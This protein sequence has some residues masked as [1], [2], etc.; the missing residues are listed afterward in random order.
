[1]MSEGELQVFDNITSIPADLRK[2]I[3]KFAESNDYCIK[4][5]AQVQKTMTTIDEKVNTT[6]GKLQDMSD[7]LINLFKVKDDEFSVAKIIENVKSHPAG[8][9]ANITSL[10]RSSD[11][12]DFSTNL[13]SLASL[14]GFEQPI[15][16][17]I[18]DRWT[19]IEDSV[20]CNRYQSEASVTKMACLLLAILGK[21]KLGFGLTDLASVIKDTKKNASVYKDLIEEIEDFA[22][23]HGFG[24][25]TRAKLVKEMKDQIDEL[26]KKMQEFEQIN[27]VCPIKFCRQTVYTDFKTLG[28]TI[29][30]CVVDMS[31][32]KMDSFIGTS[33]AATI[34]TLQQRFCK[35]KVSVEQVRRTN[36]YRV[37]PQGLVLLGSESQIGKSYLME[38]IENRVKKELFRRYKADPE[39]ET[40]QAFADVE[41]WET[42]NQSLRDKY[43]QN[44][45]GQEG[46]CIDDCFTNSDHMEHPMLIT[47]ISPRAIPTYQAD[48]TSK[49][50]PYN[51]RY[52]MLSCN[53]FPRESKTISNPHALANRFP[54]FVHCSLKPGQTPPPP[55]EDGTINRDFD[56]L[57]LHLSTGNRYY[58]QIKETGAVVC[59]TCYGPC[60][61]VT[62][63]EI[64][65]QMVTR[66]IIAQKMY[67]SQEKAY[68]Q[69]KFEM[70]YDAVSDLYRGGQVSKLGL[71]ES[72]YHGFQR[73]QIPNDL[74]NDQ[75]IYNWMMISKTQ[76]EQQIQ[77]FL[78]GANITVRNGDMCTF[79]WFVEALGVT[80]LSDF[81]LLYHEFGFKPPS[82]YSQLISDFFKQTF[83]MDYHEAYLWHDG[84]VYHNDYYASE[85]PLTQTYEE[86]AEQHYS[87]WYYLRRIFTDPLFLVYGLVFVCLVLLGL[88]G[89]FA[90]CIVINFMRLHTLI[91]TG[92][93]PANTSNMECSEFFNALVAKAVV[94]F[95]LWVIY[96]IVS[97]LVRKTK[98]WFIDPI[99]DK[100]PEEKKIFNG[101]FENSK[102]IFKKRKIYSQI[103][104]GTVVFVDQ[105]NKSFGNL[106]YLSV[107]KPI[108]FGTIKTFVYK[109][110]SLIFFSCLKDG[111]IDPAAFSLC[112]D[113]VETNE[114]FLPEKYLSE[115]LKLLVE[116][117][118]RCIKYLCYEGS[119]EYSNPYDQHLGRR[120]KTVSVYRKKESDE[121]SDDE[122]EGEGSGKPE[123]KRTNR[124]VR[125]YENEDSGS[126][127]K[128]RTNR[129]VRRYEVED[130]GAKQRKRE[131]RTVRTYESSKMFEQLVKGIDISGSDD[132]FGEED[133]VPSCVEGVDVIDITK[134]TD[135][136]DGDNVQVKFPATSAGTFEG[137]EALITTAKYESA[138]DPNANAI[139]KRIRDELNVQV[140]STECEGSA[141]FGMGVG[142]YIVFPSHLVFGTGEIVL[143]KRSTGAAVLSKECYLARVVKYC[144]NWELCGAI[145]LPLKDP[146]YKKIQPES[147][148]TQNLTFPLSALKYVPKDH[149]I[150]S[151]SLTK[152]CLQYL[153]KQG[154]IIPGMISYI[155]NYEGKLSGIN[156][157]CEIFAMQTLPMMNAQ[158]I[159]GDC[160]GAVVML[161]PSA[162]RKLIGMHIGSASNVVT[163]RDGCLDSRS[164][165]LIAILSLERLHVLTEKAYASEGEFQSGTGFP[166]VTWAKPNKYDNFHTLI[167]EDD[168][169]VHLPEDVEGSITY[170]GDLEKN[171]PPCDVKG[172]TDHYKTPFYGCFEETKKP[173]ALIEAHVPDTSKLLKDSRGNP[174]I[175]VTQ[176][177]GYAGKT[178]EIPGEIMATMIDQLKE[179]MIDCMQ[180]FAIG[181]SNNSKTAMWEALNGQYFN[182]DFDKLNE[183]S[184]A[185]IPWT[186]L[187]ATTKNDFLEH[188]RILNMYRTAEIDKFVEGFYLKDD[189]LT[190]YFKRVFNNKIEQAKH[191]RRTFSIWKACL[192][193]ELRKL[194]KVQYGTT[195]AFIAPPMESFLMGRFLFGRW[196]AAFKSNQEKLF[197]GLGIDMKSLDVTDFISKFKQYK[198]FM[199]VDYKNF[200]QKLL[201]Q[202]IKGVAVIIIETIRH[203]EHNDEYANARY[204]YFEELINTIICASKTLFMTNRGNKSG[205]VLT[206][207]LNCL[208]NFMYGWYVFIK[209]TG[210]TS[211]QTYMRYVRDKN[212]G[213]DKAMGLTQ[214]AVDM[215]F[216]FHAYKRIMAEIGQTVTPGNKSDVELPYFENICELQFLK[217]NFYQLFPTIWIAPLDKTSIES[218]FNYSCL[219]EEE[220]EEWQATIREQLIEAMLHGK[221][222][223]SVFVKK[224]R[225]FVSTCRFKH[226]YPELRE[227]IMPILLNRYVDILRS[228][229]LRIGVLSP[230]DLQNIKIH[231]ESIFENGRTRLR[232]YIKENSFESGN[233]TES[234]DKSLMSVMDNVKR[235]IQQAGEAFYNLGL[236]YGNYSPA[237]VN[238]ET[239][240][241]FEGVQSDFGPPVKVMSADGPVYAFDLGQSHGLLPKQIPTVMDVAMSLPDNI[242]HFQL[243]DPVYLNGTQPRVV[244]SPTLKDIAPKAEVLMDIFQY[245]RAKM[246]L[247]RIDSRP[248]LGFSQLIK[249][250]L[251]STSATDD[252]AFNRQGVTYNLAK[253]PIMYFLV[254]FCD[255]DFMK[256]RDEKWFKVLIEQVTP[257]ILRTD[258]PEPFRFR[259]SFEVLEL[260][261]FVHKN[262]QATTPV[263][264]GIPLSIVPTTALSVAV[265]N[266]PLLGTGLVNNGSTITLQ[267]DI[268]AIDGD[269]GGTNQSNTSLYVLRQGTSGVLNIVNYGTGIQLQFVSAGLTY[270]LLRDSDYVAAATGSF[271]A[272][273]N[274]L[275][276]GAVATPLLGIIGRLPA[277]AR[278]RVEAPVVVKAKEP[279]HVYASDILDHEVDRKF[280]ELYWQNKG[281]RGFVLPGHK[282]EGPGNSLNSGIPSN[283]MDAFAR[284]HDLQYAWASYLLANKRIDQPTFEAKIH[285]ADEE[286]AINANLTSLDG[287]AANLGM[288][289][290]K[291]VEHFTGLLYPSTG[292]YESEEA[293]DEE[294]IKQFSCVKPVDF[295]SILKERCDESGEDLMYN[296]K[297]LTS[298]D[299]APLYEC[300]CVVGDRRFSAV[301]IGKKKSKRMVSYIM[302]LALA[303]GTYQ[304]DIDP[305]ASEPSAPM[306]P[307][308][309]VAVASPGSLAAG[310]TVGTIGAKIE[311]T[312]Q[313]FVPINTVTIQANAA[314]NDML[315]KMR[316]HPGNFTSGG[317]E[318]QAQIA[319]RN[320]VFSGPGIVNGKI[321]YNTFKVTSSANA[322]QNAR[323]IIAQA[324]VEFT[325]DEIDA[326]KATDLKQFPNREHFLHGTETIFNPQ[327]VNRLPVIT[328]HATD[329]SNTNGWLVAKILE[330]SLVADSTAP[331][332]T[333][334]VCA[335]SVVYSMPRTPTELPTVAS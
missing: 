8:L 182:D 138:V 127:Q 29:E 79:K 137:T 141:L 299:N 241:Q 322:F 65:N 61:C 198:Y 80:E 132:S 271:T 70:F 185:G 183:K 44:Q 139:L 236:N 240:I 97:F 59:E 285:A 245:H 159:P 188:K 84:R 251:T 224:L 158:T 275:Q 238:P 26:L 136:D 154:F 149:D 98:T 73:Y 155:K 64:V 179:Y 313:D 212:F 287:I 211:L 276:V 277:L 143:F 289:V 332:L 135:F 146:E 30:K 47:Y 187:G 2:A 178:Y 63:D 140:Y 90:M 248:P 202:F 108:V 326:L 3:N 128:K 325:S 263:V 72:D 18:R 250:A 93:D 109:G 24:F 120:P 69:D 48:L 300:V 190:R 320:H 196:K 19:K 229:L 74:K 330:N 206:T 226:Y 200:D 122:Y 301:E 223:Y 92:H 228:Y 54:V 76:N 286:L 12:V 14:L 170:Y 307:M 34:F 133:Y 281:K 304:S 43:D 156:V 327:W 10:Y 165:G 145:I 234:L 9:L 217:R 85:T 46:H 232:Y 168:I 318:S 288:R 324:P 208:V 284:K 321:S 114:I 169:G 184:S 243:L 68:K 207:E 329:A 13:I 282:Y 102:V 213:D 167:S 62:I 255:R 153:P 194:E 306:N 166:K 1:M 280:E 52:V 147:R 220:I 197:H 101:E 209:T 242:K 273:V 33:M 265:V 268:L 58:N 37:V 216:N 312:E 112:L 89:F 88:N 305:A 51:A 210:D 172:K 96:K 4:M 39:N 41:R 176:L 81:V 201:A 124:S 252:S 175:L 319:Y 67:E 266:N 237:E 270:T 131:N 50:L 164:T 82:R 294:L 105:N 161:H 123:H 274:G 107:G 260:D 189:K 118:G 45:Q 215:G 28:A 125:K 258:V 130:S 116:Q 334:W 95:I 38:E 160:G 40:M 203:Y 31:K 298:P 152:Y 230:S 256:S 94:A 163:M 279:I 257:P 333:Y 77:D 56:W 264:E 221:K 113:R 303:D 49:G 296:F 311:V 205:N 110:V 126:K 150:G 292:K 261:Y 117:H 181:T 144:K 235:Y 199:D 103:N 222:Y 148:P 297:R 302:L 22:E 129:S 86:Y 53:T 227:A 111:K 231:C 233:F 25:S 87:M 328:N 57:N 106:S 142:R 317:V 173:S 283:E 100:Y 5:M 115:E 23:E 20:Q 60:E 323:I 269:V 7:S 259:P 278:K 192:K 134:S 272:R 291:F 162:T 151:R 335:N 316:I 244:L 191:L 6:S 121:T 75:K 83:W 15:I 295:V 174:S 247:L 310:Q 186:N 262:R 71:S 55:S 157:K 204:V 214:E 219:T 91:K 99:W 249:V 11:M 308:P 27:V 293:T 331:R 17:G 254:P 104:D 180:G 42:W 119:Y 36:G 309:P 218:V 267:G 177:S 195:R 246:C 193:D 78:D 35:L 171:Q 21:T 66:L 253:C 225:E 239:D 16:N 315:F 314:T 290:K 32:K